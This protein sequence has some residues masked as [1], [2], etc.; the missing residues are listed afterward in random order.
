MKP[1]SYIKKLKSIVEDNAFGPMYK[2][3]ESYEFDKDTL[4]HLHQKQIFDLLT[5]I[6]SGMLNLDPHVGLKSIF[7]IFT[8]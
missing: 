2:P 8:S 5:W 1:I 6:L 7:S 3:L 4:E